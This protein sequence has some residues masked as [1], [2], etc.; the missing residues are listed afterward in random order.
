MKTGLQINAISGIRRTGILLPCV[1]AGFLMLALIGGNPELMAGLLIILSCLALM[2][3]WPQTGTLVVLFAIYSNIGV[4]A[5]RAPTAVQVAA[6]S[7]NQNPR[8]VVVL[9][10][11]SLLLCVPLLYQIFVCR[12]KL[13]FDRVFVLMLIFLA[14]LLGSSAFARDSRIMLS[15]LADYLLE[16]LLLYFVLDNLIRDLPT[17][18]RVMWALLVA[19]SFMAGLSVLQKVTHTETKMYGGLAQTES[20]YHAN[21]RMLNVVERSIT[22]NKVSDN[23]ELAGQIRAAGPIG[24]TNRYGQILL[25][26][27]PLAVLQFGTSR[28]WRLQSIAALAAALILCGMLLTFSRGNLVAGIVGLGL[29]A[30]WGLLKPRHV[31]GVVL[32]VSLLVGLFQPAIASRMLTLERLKSL[33]ARRYGN[34]QAPDGSAIRRYVEN[35]S[36]W[37]VFLDHP[38]LGVGPGHF[39]A[40]YSNDYG[41]RLG[42]VEQTH[43]YRAHNLYLET[44]AETGI[45]GFVCFASI[46]GVT[47]GGLWKA[48]KR[49]AHSDPDLARVATAF[50]IS[51]SAYATSAVFAHLSYPRYFWLLIAVSSAAIR[52]VHSESKERENDQPLLCPQEA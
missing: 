42:L 41:N 46:F 30:Y 28:S 7:A 4:L 49:L 21:P 8:I 5:M 34:A 25:V 48:R 11:L 16:G 37:R 44:L 40:Y 31:F 24:E 18:R 35:V 13:I 10:G 38:A 22:A 36:A 23:G 20:D 27:L 14:A 39:A 26:L 15:E 52:I 50:L 6:G 9:G 29:M 3:R 47:M 19:G 51:L 45:V 12:R 32:G 1:C 2:L 43:Y 17:L 33:A